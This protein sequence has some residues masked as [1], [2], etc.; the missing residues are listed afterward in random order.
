MPDDPENQAT[1]FLYGNNLLFQVSRLILL[2]G[3]NPNVRTEFLGNA[4]LLCVASKEGFS[5]MVAL[6]L[7]F[8]ADINATSDNGMS[9]LCYSAAAG[10]R[11]VMRMLCVRNARVRSCYIQFFIVCVI[12]I[13]FL[14]PKC[15]L[16]KFPFV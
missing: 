12:C 15:S 11:E 6:L 10:H 3:G 8:G 7:E 4:P 9:A 13:F 2:A 5:D 16:Y 1:Y 14:S